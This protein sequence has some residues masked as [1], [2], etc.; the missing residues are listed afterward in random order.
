MQTFKGRHNDVK[1]FV[2][3]GHATKREMKF[4]TE[5]KF[6]FV[7]KEIRK[8]IVLL[9]LFSLRFSDIVVVSKKLKNFNTLTQAFA[10]SNLFEI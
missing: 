4:A 9:F 2:E 6:F 5:K 10:I 8:K 3:D 7:T 1:A